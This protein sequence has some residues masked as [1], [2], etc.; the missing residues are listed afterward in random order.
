MQDEATNARAGAD[1]DDEASV[2]IPVLL[3]EVIAA[4]SP[5]PGGRYLDATFGGG[6]HTR[7]ILAASGPDGRVL[8]LDADP[9]AIERAGP[10]QRAYG[11]RL[12]AVVANFVTLES[13]VR[14]AGLLPLHGALFDLGLSSDELSSA[15]RGFSFRTPGPLD[16]RFGPSAERTAADLLN[17]SSEEELA[18]ILF[19]FGEERHGRRIARAIVRA[20]A[21][22]PFETTTQLARVVTE[23]LPTSRADAHRI[24]PATRTFQALRIAVNRELDVLREALGA[25]IELLAPGA[26]LAVISFHSLEDRIV[27]QFM[28]LEARGC[29]CPPRAPVCVCGHLARLR[30]ITKKPIRPGA[31]EIEL[32]P[33][34]RSAVL[35]VAERLP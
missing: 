26:R 13:Q 32:N 17:D 31:E 5:R 4:L 18:T 10:L 27:K 22:A 12:V 23:A 15:E 33:R 25:V 16:M 19:Q 1:A 14:S 3:N 28:Q 8:A 20:R 2:H 7:A 30:V 9:A 6:G 11:A 35:R 24:H 34:A 29:V 21:T